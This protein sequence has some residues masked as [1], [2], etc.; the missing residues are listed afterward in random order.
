MESKLIRNTSFVDFSND[1][2]V[3]SCKMNRFDERSKSISFNAS[4]SFKKN[5]LTGFWTIG[6]KNTVVGPELTCPTK[7]FSNTSHGGSWFASLV[8]SNK[9]NIEIKNG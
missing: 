3:V 2:F 9:V 8:L 4:S 5:Q 1:R 7:F 6:R